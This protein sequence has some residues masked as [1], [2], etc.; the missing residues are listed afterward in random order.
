MQA[1]VCSKHGCASVVV[2]L[3]CSHDENQ[4]V[5]ASLLVRASFR[6]VSCGREK[7]EGA[8]SA[9]ARK[10]A[11]MME[12]VLI[13]RIQLRPPMLSLPLTSSYS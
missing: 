12:P 2:I 3:F 9:E 10:D 13:N 8:R 11:V 1:H 5:V 6:F 7:G 4:V